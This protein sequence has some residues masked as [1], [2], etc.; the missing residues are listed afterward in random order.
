MEYDSNFTVFITEHGPAPS[1]PLRYNQERDLFGYFASSTSV[2]DAYC[3]AMFAMGAILAPNKFSMADERKI[4]WQFT[5]NAYRKSFQS[6]PMLATLERLRDDPA[7]VE[8]R[9]IRN[10]LTHRAIPPRHFSLPVGSNRKPTAML[11]QLNIDLGTNTT[12]ERRKQVTRLLRTAM[13][14]ARTFVDS[15]C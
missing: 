10:V 4:D 3:F 8:L 1:L 2:F 13:E 12:L 11:G 14:A 9:E 15:H 5:L 6:D 7:Y